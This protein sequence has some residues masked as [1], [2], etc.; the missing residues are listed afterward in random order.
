MDASDR[1]GLFLIEADQGHL[2]AWVWIR[3]EDVESLYEG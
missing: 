2:E 1:C 3:V